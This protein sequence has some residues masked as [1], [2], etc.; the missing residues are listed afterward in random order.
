M[1]SNSHKTVEANGLVHAYLEEGPADGDVVL[2]L[3]GFPDHAPSFRHQS[4]CM[5]QRS[6]P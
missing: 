6:S 1:T 4:C 3:H 5:L 2:L